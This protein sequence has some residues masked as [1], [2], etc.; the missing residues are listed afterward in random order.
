MT[1]RRDDAVMGSDETPRQV[2]RRVNHVAL[3]RELLIMREDVLHCI[4][5]KDAYDCARNEH[6]SNQAQASRGS[7]CTR[8]FGIWKVY[9]HMGFSCCR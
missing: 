8:L 7:I 3:K 5:V 4:V 2:I 9:L 6:S 1:M